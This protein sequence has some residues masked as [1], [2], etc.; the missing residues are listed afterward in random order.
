VHEVNL[1]VINDAEGPKK[2]FVA[3]R[4]IIAVLNADRKQE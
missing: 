4:V 2:L 1:H 3:S